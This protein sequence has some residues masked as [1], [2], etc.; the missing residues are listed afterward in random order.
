MPTLGHRRR[1]LTRG[2]GL[3]FA[4]LDMTLAADRRGSRLAAA[5]SGILLG[6]AALSLPQAAACGTIGCLVVSRVRPTGGWLA[7]WLAGWEGWASPLH[8]QPYTTPDA[9]FIVATRD[10][11]GDD[12]VSE[13]FPALAR[14]QSIGTAQ[15][16]EWLGR[17]GFREQLE[18][19]RAILACAGVT[20]RCYKSVDPV[21]HL[22]VPNGRLVGPYSD[23]DCCGALRETL[24]EAGCSVIYDGHGAT[25]ARP[26]N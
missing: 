1:W 14:R 26:R 2:I 10:V 16:S 4:L 3:L 15:G 17:A 18:S 22:F 6:L 5:M 21:A 12:E 20:A 7:G 13:W 19:H 25:I 11:G 9:I 8:A 23:R 24:A